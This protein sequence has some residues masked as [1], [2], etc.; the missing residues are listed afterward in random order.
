MKL[1]LFIGSLSR[2][3]AERCACN[4]SSFL[5]QNGHEVEILTV[6][7]VTEPYKLDSAVKVQTLLY[8][9]ERKNAIWNTVLRF[10]RFCLYLIRTKNDAYIVLLPRTTIMLLAFKWLTKAKIIISE[11][12][13][14]YSYKPML[15]FF[16]KSLSRMADGYVFQ[17]ECAR[18]WYANVVNESPSVIIPNAIN[19]DFIRPHYTGEKQKIILGVGRLDSQKN[20]S[21]LINAFA[22]IADKFSD[23]NLFIYG[24][25][26]K[27]KS[28][29]RLICDLGLTSRVFLPGNVSDIASVMERSYMFVLPSNSEGMPN[30]L[31]EAMAIGLPCISTDCPCG[32]PKYLIQD[33]K[34]GFLVPVGNV[35][36]MSSTIEI[37]LSDTDMARKIGNAASD[38]KNTLSPYTIYSRW[39]NFIELVIND[40][41][42]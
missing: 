41:V 29:E 8:I 19:S 4:L 42:S 11:R 16:L 10:M 28:L 35:E 21:F 23:Y 40:S 3:G 17:T 30:A 7:E 12:A 32:G 26:E 22:M 24:E 13:N 27:R 31:I 18:D 34:N 36:R 14:P 37:L 6:S 20:F 25:G 15:A 1:T 2:G 39:M 9:N 33:G 5:V 38:V